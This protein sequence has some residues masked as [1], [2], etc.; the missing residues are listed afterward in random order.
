M[1]KNKDILIKDLKMTNMV[2]R[3]LTNENIIT[4][5]DFTKFKYE[6]LIEILDKYGI[7][8]WYLRGV[9]FFVHYYGFTFK[10]EY[11]EL[12]LRPEIT[13]I[14]LETLDMDLQIRN[15]LK[16]KGVIYTL[17]ELLNT[18]CIEIL[19]LKGMGPYKLEMLKKYIHELGYTLKN[20]ELEVKDNKR[21]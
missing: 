15:I 13:N 9:R 2:K 12:E 16:L 14:R 3:V 20:E 19:S 18:D 6:E 11:D 10:G 7:S 21:I 8:E 5:E 4:I 1:E 17:G